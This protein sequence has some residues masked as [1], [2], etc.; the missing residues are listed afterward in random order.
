MPESDGGVGR[1]NLTRM[2]QTSYVRTSHLS[3][4]RCEIAR[5]ASSSE[6]RTSHRS[7]TTESG[8]S[9]LHAS[10]RHKIGSKMT[11]RNENVSMGAKGS[12]EYSRMVTSAEIVKKII[13]EITS[14]VYHSI[15]ER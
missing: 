14:L 12:D 7:E 4:E 15:L 6:R 2:S 11:F 3:G 1:Y 8:V 5:T 13:S 9:E 10:A